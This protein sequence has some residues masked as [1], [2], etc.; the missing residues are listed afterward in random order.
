MERKDEAAVERQK[1]VDDGEAENDDDQTN[2]STNV[3]PI[4]APKSVQTP[5]SPV[6]SNRIFSSG[7]TSRTQ[8]SSNCSVIKGATDP[9]RLHYVNEREQRKQNDPKPDKNKPR[10]LPRGLQSNVDAQSSAS[11]DTRS[12]KHHSFISEV[13]DVRHMEKALLGLLDDFHSGK[14]KAFGFGCTMEQMT[15]IRQQQ[16]SLAKLHFELGS[17][18]DPFNSKND[19]NAQ[20]NMSKLVQKLE[21]LSVSIEKLHSSNTNL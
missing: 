20:E 14:L 8:D 11:F 13:P 17:G 18:G 2:I 9:P 6:L 3:P 5:N 1:L 4:S 12:L 19:L 16:E 7:E 15:D 10:K 21:N